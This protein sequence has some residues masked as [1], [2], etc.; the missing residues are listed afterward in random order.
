MLLGYVYKLRPTKEQLVELESWLSMLYYHYNFCLKDRKYN[1]NA[2]KQDW[3]SD[4]NFPV[5]SCALTC[6]I[7]R[8]GATGEVY[9]SKPDR[10]TGLLKRRNASAIQDA[11]LVDLKKARPWYK[12][13]NSTAL[14]QNIKRLDNAYKGFWQNGK[15]FP[16]PKRRS[17]FRSFTITNIGNE[18]ITKTGIRIASLGWVD[19]FNSRSIPDGFKVKSATIRKKADG[20][21]ISIK[22]EDKSIPQ[23]V[24][25][26][27]EDVKTVLGCDLGLTKLVHCS[28][29]SDIENPRFS[30]NK[31][32]K[33]LM[34]VRSRRA[35]RKK[36]KA[37]KRKAHNRLGRL[38]KR[39]ADKRNGYQWKVAKDIV[40]KADAI[41]LE[42]LNI[43][44]MKSR[45]KPKTDVSGACHASD[46]NGKYLKNGQSRKVG[47]NR[48]ISDAAWYSLG[49]KIQVM[50]AKSGVMVVKVNPS[51][52]SQECS[53]CH[54]VDK[55][56][57]DKERFICTECG[58]IDHADKQAARTIKQRGILQAG[59]AV[60]CRIPRKYLKKMV[61]RDLPEPIQL[62]LG[63]V[64][65]KTPYP[66]STGRKESGRRSRSKKRLPGNLLGEQLSL[67]V[68]DNKTNPN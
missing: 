50:A 35:S 14:Q 49:Q 63:L 55:S 19:Y 28:D 16:K 45:C 26:K 27:P 41:I 48:S 1:Y 18:D 46:M 57:R 23:A 64:L 32:N 15:G 36:G 25:V 24:E 58:H 12:Q 62:D 60:R 8:D 20:W 47:L 13:V 42:D 53:R 17:K 22:I 68:M 38:H 56:N 61:R 65:D 4:Y 33:R 40:K 30:T 34:R 3:T 7:S 10:K 66:E 51:H 9:T 31:K 11:N 54:Y 44:G 29:N 37:N 39:I 21:Y 59:L 67:F 5:T 6:C 2:S 52:T 43:K